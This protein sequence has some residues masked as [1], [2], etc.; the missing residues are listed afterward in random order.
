MFR[1]A[2]WLCLVASLVAQTS[3]P[4]DLSVKMTA[5]KR[6]RVHAKAGPVLLEADKGTLDP[7]SDS[8]ELRGR[9]QVTLP[10]RSDRNLIRYGGRAVVT[11]DA[12]VIAADRISLKN[13]L[14]HGQGHVTVRTATARLQ[15][16]EIQVYLRLGDGELRGHIRVNGTPVEWLDQSPR[17]LPTRSM[18]PEI[19]RK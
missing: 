7:D 3:P 15:A 18:P 13:G 8:L 1:A 11:E 4:A 16:D 6:G 14:L 5:G 12:L 10:A 19:I 2:F 17:R 9:A